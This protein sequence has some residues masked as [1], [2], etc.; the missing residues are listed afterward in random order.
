MDI[1]GMI[2]VFTCTLFAGAAVYINLVE[3]P[4]RLACGTEIAATHWVPSYKRAAV[5]QGSL[6]A[7]A[8]V[9]GMI[10]WAVWGG[11]LWIW[12]AII[13]L[14]VIPFTLFVILPTNN[15]LLDPMRDRSSAD[16]R[17]LLEVWGHLHAVRSALGVIASV[18]FIWA[19][20]V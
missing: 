13:I 1:V 7:I 3:H 10:R 2:A 17:H 15:Q 16:T 8:A 18:L 6:A 5:M 20:T 9:A 12:S 14:A 4:A 19:A 11:P